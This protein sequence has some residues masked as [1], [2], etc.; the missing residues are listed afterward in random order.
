MDACVTADRFS[1]VV[2]AEFS[3]SKPGEAAGATKVETLR[4]VSVIAVAPFDETKV[5]ADAEL[6][7]EIGAAIEEASRVVHAEFGAPKILL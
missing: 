3:E 1:S 6:V 2:W 4:D 7:L 5:N